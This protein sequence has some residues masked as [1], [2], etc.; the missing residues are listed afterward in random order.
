LT[1]CSPCQPDRYYDDPTVKSPWTARLDW[2]QF[3]DLGQ[4]VQLPGAS[5]VSANWQVHD[6]R[7]GTV[8]SDDWYAKEDPAYFHGPDVSRL[9]RWHLAVIP[10]T[11]NRESTM[12]RVIDLGVDG[13]I[14]D[15]PDLLVLVAKRN[16]L[17]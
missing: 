2:W 14:T 17:R 6:P 15:D 8:S 4:L 1:G 12:E 9:H 13:M 10:Y 7:Q 11:I 16:G 3:Q 5:V